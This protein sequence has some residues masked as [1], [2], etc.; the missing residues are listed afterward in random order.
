M[1]SS[2]GGPR[3]HAASRDV[4]AD[5]GESADKR[6]IAGG[7]PGLRRAIVSSLVLYAALPYALYQLLTSRG[8]PATPALALTA[9]FPVAGTLYD[10]RRNGRLDLIGAASLLTIAVG[11]AGGLLSND[12]L[13]ILARESLLTGALSVALLTGALSVACVVSLF[14]RRPL[15]F[16]VSRQGFSAGDPERVAQFDRLWT[17]EPEFRRTMRVITVVWGVTYALEAIVRIVLALTLPVPTFLAVS[18]PLMLVV[19]AA[20]LAWTVFY[21]RGARKR[22]ER[23]AL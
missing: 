15:M 19:T 23:K 22:A 20:V 21:G 10:W 12:P 16:Y 9:V 4:S 1:T 11:V 3:Q 18:S 8:M 14:L 7:G 6:R 5:A 13:F 2:A 17:A